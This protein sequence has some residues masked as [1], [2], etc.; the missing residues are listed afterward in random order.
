MGAA[1]ALIPTLAACTTWEAQERAAAPRMQL[2]V[3]RTMAQFSRDSGLLPYDAM[4][5]RGGKVF[6]VASGACRLWLDAVPDGTGSTADDW[7]I[8]DV[9]WSGPC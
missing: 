5:V 8:T 9:R 2:L 1:I 6:L 4:P 3:G 7:R